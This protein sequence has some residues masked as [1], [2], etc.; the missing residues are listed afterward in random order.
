MNQPREH[1]CI[2]RIDRE[3][4]HEDDPGVGRRPTQPLEPLLLKA[5]DVARL[6][7]LSRSTVFTLLAAHD[8]PVV[9]IGRSV[10]VPR[11]ELER[12]IDERTDP[13]NGHAEAQEPAA[14]AF[15]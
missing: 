7:G 14:G 8:L 3:K 5:V 11:A 13:A 6:L 10:R 4:P 12:W 2:G 9:R 1:S 15:A